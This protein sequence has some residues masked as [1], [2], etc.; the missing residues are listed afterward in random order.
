MN[1]IT[2]E[3]K[4][5][6][7]QAYA[8]GFIRDAI[9]TNRFE[10]SYPLT[11]VEL[12]G[13]MENMSRT[14][15]RNALIRLEHEGMVERI[16]GKGLFVTQVNISDL[17]EI[18]EIRL[19]LESTAVK[20][21]VE[22]AGDAMRRELRQ[23]LEKHKNC[24]QS[25]DD[26]NAVKCDSA[27]HYAIAKGSMN[28]RLYSIIFNLIEESSRGAL[29]T[30]RDS[31]RIEKSIAQHERVLDAIEADDAELAAA[32]V[33]THLKDWIEYVKEM[34]FKNYYWFNR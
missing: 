27:F 1:S 8:Y 28:N 20:L 13:M 2:Q 21:F 11:E 7:K 3:Y 4:K 34:Q 5:G 15:V 9:M 14:P 18:S 23:L 22:R 24:H 19:S 31:N 6:D 25:G 30:Q 12:S 16:P 17:L 26:L 10:P 33:V 29:M 32:L